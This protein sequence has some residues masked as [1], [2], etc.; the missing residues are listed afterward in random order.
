MQS[1]YKRLPN[2]QKIQ[3]PRKFTFYVINSLKFSQNLQ[4]NLAHKDSDPLNTNPSQNPEE[5]LKNYVKYKI[6]INY[7]RR[8]LKNILINYFRRITR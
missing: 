6:S 7:Q 3:N 5:Y 8:I 4:S 1:L 2:S